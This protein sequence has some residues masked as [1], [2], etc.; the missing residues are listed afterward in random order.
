MTSEELSSDGD[1]LASRAAFLAVQQLYR[2][3]FKKGESPQAADDEDDSF[4]DRFD[5]EF[6]AIDDRTGA[7]EL[8]TQFKI[9]DQ[10][11]LVGDL[12]TEGRFTGALKYLIRFR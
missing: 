12:D 2:K 11:Y 4:L 1:A 9:T 8:S 3:I 7:R 6:G 5:F 10:T